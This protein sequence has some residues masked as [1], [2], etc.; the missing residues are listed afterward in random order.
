MTRERVASAALVAAV[1][2]ALLWVLLSGGGGRPGR[3]PA[4]ALATF[5]VALPPPRPRIPP[6]DRPREAE[7]PA[8]IRDRRTAVVAP[9]PVMPL[10]NPPPVVAAIVPDTG[11]AALGGAASAGSGT[12]AGGV[13]AG[14][15]GGG[16]GG[17]GNRAVLIAGTIRDRDYP[18][19]ARAARAEGTSVV[20][21]TV[22]ID[23]RPRDCRVA[24][25][26]GD[27]ALDATT[28]RLIEERFRYAPARD[29]EGRPVAEERG[30]RQWWWID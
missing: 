17:G 28:C 18:R 24:T 3:A 1:H 22:G 29:A 20:R 30:W 26:S 14:T 21:F 27:P 12:G 4:A 9:P 16:T 6:R 7:G 23:G 11:A 2:A 13:G 8:G 15:G 25:S 10:L 19:A 5:D